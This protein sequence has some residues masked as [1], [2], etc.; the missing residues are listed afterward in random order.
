[1]KPIKDDIKELFHKKD[2]QSIQNFTKDK[3]LNKN[4]KVFINKYLKPL[5]QNKS[6]LSK[7]LPTKIKESILRINAIAKI[8]SKSNPKL[9]LRVDLLDVKNFD[10][11]SASS[12]F[13]KTSTDLIFLPGILVLILTGSTSASSMSIKSF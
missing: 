10:Y 2:Y 6:I 11:Y 4:E 1:M 7:P 5:I 12:T 8:L 3:R 9:D 13:T